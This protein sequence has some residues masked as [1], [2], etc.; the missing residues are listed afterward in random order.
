MAVAVVTGDT[1]HETHDIFII[2]IFF[3]LSFRFC[4]FW[5]RCYYP[6]T[7]RNTVSPICRI[8][9][10]GGARVNPSRVSKLII[11]SYRLDDDDCG[12][13]SYILVLQCLVF[14]YIY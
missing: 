12:L 3:F 4:L 10:G 5:Y 11:S 6:H 1:Q 9:F 8:F 7:S 2:K 14:I 13:H